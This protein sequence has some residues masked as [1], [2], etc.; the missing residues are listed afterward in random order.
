VSN[1]VRLCGQLENVVQQ[2]EQ[3][4]DKSMSEMFIED[5][6]NSES[7][8]ENPD[9]GL[10]KRLS[11]N[12][13]IISFEEVEK[14]ITEVSNLIA[15]FRFDHRTADTSSFVRCTLINEKKI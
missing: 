4:P 2:Q 5:H 13:R 10:D 9:D 3:E 15:T 8:S 6:L 7:D 11:Q 1:F 12:T 14:K